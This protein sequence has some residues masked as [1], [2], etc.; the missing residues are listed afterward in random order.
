MQG[1]VAGRARA[2]ARMFAL[3]ATLALSGPTLPLWTQA[4]QAEIRV[5]HPEANGQVL[6][7]AKPEEVG[8]SSERL[9]KI[10]RVLQAEIDAERLPGAVVMIARRG[11]LAYAESFGLRD[12][13]SNA[14]LTNDAL[15]R[16]YSMTKPMAS[17]AAM[18]LMEDGRL[19]LTD[20]VSKYLPEFKNLQVSVPRG[21]A[22]GEQGF[23]LVAAER[24]PTIQDLL[25]HTAG[26]AYG[27]ITTNT[28]VKNA[29]QKAGLWKPDFDYNVGD[30]APEE[31]VTRLASAP[32]AYQPGT[33]WQY[34]L[35]SDL[36]GRVVEKA[37][38][39]RLSA[40]L[41][42]RLFRPL[43]MND[44]GFSVPAGK[45][46]RMAGAFDKDPATG[47]PIRLIDGSAP[48]GDS[49]GAG[50]YSTASDYLRF[51][52]MLLDGGRLGDT[53][54][55]SRP[56][57]ELM[58][59]DHLGDRIRPIATPGDLLMGVPGYTFGLGFMVRKEAGIAG[60][61]GSAGEFMWAGYAGTFFWVDPKEEL[62]V[63][64]MT[65]MPGPSRAYYRREIKQL[66]YQ[67][68]AD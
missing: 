26:L 39:Q 1:T 52:Q 12:K 34:S 41:D 53:R 5:R 51:A 22:L 17:V 68:I 55:L 6:T 20:P 33:V 28:L 38:G 61:P 21:N 45:N 15:F 18:M 67:A 7:P 66:V 63:V 46:E 2:R 59:A 14:K 49:G 47:T 30:L 62:A 8:L 40:F 54:V 24:Q 3:A 48:K 50:A 64:L 29:Y 56:T 25:R 57:I 31:F 11:R 42:E 37:S 23:E 16:I 44:T 58:T 60:V 43:K 36:L 4:A 9:A 35:A 32:L 65:Q 19:Q 10:G 13:A 27:E